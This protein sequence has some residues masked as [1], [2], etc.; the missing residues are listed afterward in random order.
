MRIKLLPLLVNIKQ[1]D[2]ADAIKT[3]SFWVLQHV[4]AIRPLLNQ[5]TQV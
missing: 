5:R 3:N 4:L 2:K 1:I